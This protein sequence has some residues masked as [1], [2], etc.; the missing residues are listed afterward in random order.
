MS[1]FQFMFDEKLIVNEQEASS[2]LQIAPAKLKHL[3]QTGVIP[4]GFVLGNT[5]RIRRSTV[6]ELM[7]DGAHTFQSAE[8]IEE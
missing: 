4:N 5:I 2:A 8:R 1:P 6:I 7:R 3:V